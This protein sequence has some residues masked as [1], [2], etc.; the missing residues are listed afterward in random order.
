MGK[1]SFLARIEPSRQR[2]KLIDWPF[3]VEGDRPKVKVRILGQHECEEAYF[4]AQD[5][6]KDRKPPISIKDPAFALRERAEIVFRAFS[7]DGEPLADDVDELLEQPQS[8][9]DELNSTYAQFYADVAATPYTSKDMAA[10]V[11]LLK[12]SI[13]ADLLSALP[14]SWLIGLITTLASQPAPSTPANEL[15]L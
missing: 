8:V 3:P 7:V 12:K 13:P 14:S 11:E 5:H 9:I 2:W 4:A 10:L 1:K 6:F 15:G